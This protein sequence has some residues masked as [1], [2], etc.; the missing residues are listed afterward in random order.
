MLGNYFYLYANSYSQRYP[1]GGD[2]DD[3]FDWSGLVVYLNQ[4]TGKS[5]VLIS[6]SISYYL[7]VHL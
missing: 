1:R 4:A 2:V 6:Q 7:L 3:F 5:E